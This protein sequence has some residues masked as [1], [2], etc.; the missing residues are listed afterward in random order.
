MNPICKNLLVLL[1]LLA[2]T[3]C[4]KEEAIEPKSPYAGFWKLESFTSDVAIDLNEDGAAER[5]FMK[6]LDYYFEIK[7]THLHGEHNL[8][9]E[10][11]YSIKG[12]LVLDSRHMPT[13]VFRA[14]P[15]TYSLQS[16]WQTDWTWKMLYF[17]NNELIRFTQDEPWNVPESPLAKEAWPKYTSYN[18]IDNNNLEILMDQQFYDRGAGEWKAAKMVAV[19]QKL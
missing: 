13:D 19:F 14:F 11:S 7:S 12:A 6:E 8:E 9:I 17:E 15:Y 5:D 3:A 4:E 18:F 1:M 10:E 2:F 16:R